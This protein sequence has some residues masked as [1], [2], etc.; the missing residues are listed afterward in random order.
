MTFTKTMR[1]QLFVGVSFLVFASTAQ[2]WGWDSDNNHTKQHLTLDQQLYQAALQGD[3]AKARTLLDKGADVNARHEDDKTP[4]FA[5]ATKGHLDIV[6]LLVEHGAQVAIA[7]MI[8]DTPLKWAAFGGHT[9]V[10]MFLLEHGAKEQ[11]DVADTSWGRTALLDA[12]SQQHE[13]T[14]C[15]LVHQG[16]DI[17]KTD[18]HNGMTPLFYAAHMNM[19]TLAQV[20]LEAKA[21]PN[22][23]DR[24]GNTPLTYVGQDNQAMVDLLVNYGAREP[25]STPDSMRRALKRLDAPKGTKD[26]IAQKIAMFERAQGNP[27]DSESLRQVLDFI[28]RL[29]WGKTTHDNKDITNAQAIL[30]KSHAHM[31]KVKDEILDFVTLQIMNSQ[32][33][34]VL[35]LVGPPGTGK[36]SIVQAIA[37]ALGRN[38]IRVGMGGV[39][40]ASLIRGHQRAYIGSEPGIFTKALINAGSMNSVIL[41][42][43]ID[44]L[45]QGGWHGNPTSA[46]L[47]LLDPE[48]NDKFRDEYLE[49]PISFKNTLFICTANDARTI[50]GPLRDRMKMI[51]ISSYTDTEKASIVEHHLIDKITKE[52]GISRD[53][54]PIDRDLLLY[55]IRNYTHE[56]GVRSVARILRTLC[57]KVARAKLEGTNITFTKE[58]IAQ[59]LGPALAKNEPRQHENRIGVTTG[60]AWTEVGGCTL[61]VEVLTVAPGKGKLI[62]TGQLGDVMRES[63]QAAFSYVRAHAHELGIDTSVLKT[64]DVHIHVPEGATPKDGPSAGVTFVTS[65][66]SALTQQPVRGTHAMTGEVTL[67]GT[68]EAIGGLKEKVLAA[69]RDGITNIIAPYANRHDLDQEPEA[70]QGMTFI[71][72]KT[73]NDVLKTVLVPAASYATA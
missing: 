54:L 71:W 27:Y 4:L 44:K 73:V 14:A 22:A 46:L 16:A 33:P 7:N 50:P 47:E 59:Y 64:H 1:V 12:I 17:N 18:T 6:Q 65:F 9:D 68:V 36:T 10:V 72:A 3:V 8:N 21:D 41:I 51:D 55:I 58:N 43:E 37:Q 39:N 62:I 20:L 42:D 24:Q 69:K 26:L 45:G 67:R 34:T 57:A 60:L 48:Q 38:Y 66:V 13:E 32:D 28:F 70:T 56:A 35:C 49:I 2:A 40:D 61:E 31:K 19:L 11:I 5:A 30:N 25:I 15:E 52:C 29:P 63:A 23:T 53:T